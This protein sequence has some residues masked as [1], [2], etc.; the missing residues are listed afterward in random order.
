MTNFSKSGPILLTGPTL[1]PK[2]PQDT[3]QACLTVLHENNKNILS[4]YSMPGPVIS[5]GD[6]AE[7][8]TGMVPVLLRPTVYLRVFSLLRSSS[9]AL[10]LSIYSY[11][12]PLLTDSYMNSVIWVGPHATQVEASSSRSWGLHHQYIPV[13]NLEVGE[14]SITL[15]K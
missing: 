6:K 10:P 14:Y 5:T 2:I 9:S 11:A 12:I 8:R 13:S 1:C 3:H 15:F 4:T 7:S